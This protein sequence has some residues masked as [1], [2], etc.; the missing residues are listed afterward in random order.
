[1]SESKSTE[2][3][4]VLF[5][6]APVGLALCSMKDGA[7][8]AVNKAFAAL[9]G[10]T[11]DETLRLNTG[12]SRPERSTKTKRMNSSGSSKKRADT[13]PTINRTFTRMA[14]AST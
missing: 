9:L 12:T 6:E 4:R 8:V 11:P 5:D 1:M 10:R 13:A 3:Y 2:F 14:T 7:Y